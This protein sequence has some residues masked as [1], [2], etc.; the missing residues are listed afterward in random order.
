MCYIS[1]NGNFFF[2]CSFKIKS[3]SSSLVIAILVIYFSALI[4]IAYFTSRNAGSDTFFTGNKSSPWYLVAFGMIGTT[5]SGVTFISVPG[6]VGKSGFAYFQVIL[7]NLVGYL[8]V[9]QVLLPLYYKLNLVS[10]YT[11]L[12][13]RFGFWSYKS[14]SA[15]FII[16]RTI[17]AAFRLFLAVLVLD[18]FLFSHFSLYEGQPVPF[19]LVTM[20]TLGL[21]WVY[22]FKGGVKTIIWTDSFQTIFLVMAL[23][24][25][26]VFIAHE[27]GVVHIN[28][29]F[30]KIAQSG[31]S[32]IFYFDDVKSPN[33]FWK[34]FLSGI[35]L[36]ICM[37]GL[38]QDM[39]QKN[40]S[41]HNLKEARKNMFSFLG[42]FV[43]VN[44]L[45]L[46]LGALLYVYAEQKGIALPS[47]PD[48]LY[49]TLALKYFGTAAGIFF[50][51]GITASSYASSDS[52]LAALTTSFCIDFL[53]FENRTEKEKQR[54][55]FFVH[56][57]FTFLLF[58]IILLFRFLNNDSVVNAVFKVAGYTYGPLLGLFAFGLANKRQLHDKLVPFICIGSPVVCYFLNQHAAEW[59]NGYKFDFELLIL[60]GF[61]TFIGLWAISFKE[62]ISK[63]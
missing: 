35:F 4:I 10:I 34:K 5:L 43:F 63:I 41:C 20:V 2:Y 47:N 24:M 40:L 51:L 25:S 54:L 15:A 49:P 28:L 22:T 62:N 39:M 48:Y 53:Q 55:K 11:Y 18:L 56:L 33:F 29:F 45:F 58:L 44:F 23:V 46:S 61:F 42:I 36:V 3:M 6:A 27:L 12:D 50:L 14:G 38:D 32:Q 57:G 60:N 52:A 37:V 9:A 17:G 1:K 21:I 31:H 16:S 7:G 30:N 19:W 26:I 59:F 8:V 13:K